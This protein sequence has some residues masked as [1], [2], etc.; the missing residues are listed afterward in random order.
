MNSTIYFVDMTS[1]FNHKTI[2]N[3]GI[4]ASESIL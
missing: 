4:G 1:D 3:R 2:Q